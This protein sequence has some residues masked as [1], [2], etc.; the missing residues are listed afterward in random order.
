MKRFAFAWVALAAMSGALAQDPAAGYPAKPIRIIVP[1]P[2]RRQ[3][4]PACRASSA[5]SS[6]RK[7]GQPVIVDNRPGAAGNIGAELVYQ[8]EPDGY[9]LLSAPPP[10]LVINPSLYPKLAFDPT[11]FVPVTIIGGDPERAAGASEGA[12]ATRAG[13]DR[14][15]PRAIPTSS[16]TRPRAA[17]RRRTSPPRCSSRWRAGCRSRTSPT[18]ARRPRSPTCSAARWT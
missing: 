6:R 17:A 8:A 2:R 1:F 16:T 10:P 3:R 5:R 18:R 11:Q 14:A 12:G 9:T 7:W 13:A 15:T 4:R